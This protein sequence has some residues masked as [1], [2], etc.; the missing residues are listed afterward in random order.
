MSTVGAG[1]ASLQPGTHRTVCCSQEERSGTRYRAAERRADSGSETGRCVPN[2]PS[3][4]APNNGHAFGGSARTVRSKS[5]GVADGAECKQRELL[6]NSRNLSN[7]RDH[8]QLKLSSQNAA[9]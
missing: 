5:D 2:I 9:L 1:Q 7:F 6:K 4:G 8:P 3:D